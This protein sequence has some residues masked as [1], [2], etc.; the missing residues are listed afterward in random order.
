MIDHVTIRVPSIE[1]GARFYDEV[2]RLLEFSAEPHDGG[3]FCEDQ[4]FAGT[5]IFCPMQ[6]PDPVIVRSGSLSFAQ[7]TGCS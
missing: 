3:G 4:A 2:F 7:K 5:R 6:F 1:A